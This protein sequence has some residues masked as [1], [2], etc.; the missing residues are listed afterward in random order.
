MLVGKVDR[1][2]TGLSGVAGEY[3]VAAELSRRG[4]EASI[5]LKNTQ[6]VDILVMNEEA[7]RT[8]MIQVKT[9]Q[10]SKREWILSKKAERISGPR[11]FYVFVL[12]NGLDG[13]PEF[14][15]VPSADVAEYVAK[16]HSDWLKGVG[17]KGQQR[18][19]NTMRQFRDQNG[20]YQDRWELLGL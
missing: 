5:N 4:Y 10:G 9:F 20:A 16:D 3:F 12:L 18:N 19:D 8:A 6:G 17:K 1:L 11:L 2:S 7:T 15:I 13:K 14:F